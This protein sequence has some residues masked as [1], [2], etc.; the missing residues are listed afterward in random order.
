MTINDIDTAPWQEILARFRCRSCGNCCRG[1]GIV[2][3]TADEAIIICRYLGI[4]LKQ[5]QRDYARRDGRDYILRD[6]PGPMKDCIFLEN[7]RCQV[8][9]VKPQ[10]CRDFPHKW[11][12]RYMISECEGLREAWKELLR[13]DTAAK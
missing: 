4:T 3:V 11:H 12:E 9:D 5:F 7:N 6:R 10:Q 13:E 2:Q 1:G 8:H